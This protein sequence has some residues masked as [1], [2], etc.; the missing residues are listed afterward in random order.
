MSDLA[1]WMDGRGRIGTLSQ[2]RGK[3]SFAYTPEALES[4]LGLPLLSVSLPTAS[5]PARGAAVHAFFN[6]LL[7]EGEARR[8]I[9]Y[10]F[11]I[12]PDDVFALLGALGRDCAG[13]LIL[14]APDEAPPVHGAPAPVSEAHIAERIRNL[15]F[16]PLGVDQELRVSLAGMQEKLL[17]TQVEEGWALPVNGAPSTHILKPRHQLLSG[18]IANEAMCMRFAHHLGL[19]AAS[20]EIQ[21]FE[22]VEVL[23]VERFDRQRDQAGVRRIHQEDF[24]QAHGLEPERKYETA[25]GPSLARCASTISDWAPGRD[26][27]WALLDLSTV[28]VLIG[29]ADAH[30][31]NLGFLHG[32]DGSVALA[33]AYDLMSTTF[34]PQVST[35]AGMRMNG[36]T[37][38][39]A[40]DAEDLG[41]E[42]ATW[43]LDPVEARTRVDGLIDAAPAAISTAAAETD[44]PE[45][46][47]GHLTERVRRLAG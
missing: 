40:I 20:V 43:G 24:C 36:K 29:N 21:T 46:L 39:D 22:E 28:N 33:P 18:S 37:D 5:R 3:M 31:K 35:V 47:I 41:R 2:I 6:G 12:D 4:G 23:V 25:G 32:A 15:R 16:A 1:V 27:L 9:A 30:A 7:P 8:M 17:L 44:A 14:L 13:A 19:P 10:D 38:I 26:S 45:G 34:Y 42:G 11:G